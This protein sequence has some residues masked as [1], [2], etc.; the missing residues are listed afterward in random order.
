MYTYL[1]SQERPLP[2]LWTVG[3]NSKNGEWVPESDHDSREKAESRAAEL[4]KE[5]HDVLLDA[6]ED[7]AIQ[8]C[9]TDKDGLTDSMALSANA[10][11]LETLAE[12]G[13][14]RITK[15]HGR[16]V[17]GYFPANDPEEKCK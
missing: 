13:R 15:S 14:F 12:F 5:A 9:H 11:A 2:D 10:Y 6:L 1:Q 17:L 4:N 8:H 16:R 3:K 7:M